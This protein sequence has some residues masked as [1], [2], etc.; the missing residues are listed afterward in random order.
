MKKKIFIG[1]GILVVITTVVLAFTVFNNNKNHALK[2][3]KETVDRGNIEALVVTT[4]SLNPVIVVDVGSQV[5][6]KIDNIYVDFNSTVK[7]GQVIAELD[8]SQFITRVNQNEANYQSSVASLEKAKVTFENIK[9]KYDRALG[10][11]EK[12]LVSFEEKETVETQ[13]YSAKADI[14]TAESRLAQAKSQLDSSKVDLTYTV[15]RSPIDGVIIDRR[16]NIGQTVAASFQAPVLFQIANDLSKMQV[17]CSVDEADIGKVKEGQKVRFNV[18]AFPNET[19]RGTVLQVR[20]SPEI[21]QNV[22]TY[23]SIIGVSNPDLKLRPGMTATVSIISGEAKNVLRVPNAAL[24]F[25]PPPEVWEEIMAGMRQGMKGR[26]ESQT[27]GEGSRPQGDVRSPGAQG[28]GSAQRTSMMSM[29]G[30][31]GSFGRSRMSNFAR[32]WTE[33]ENGKLHLISIRTG[34][35]DNTYTEI[36]EIVRGNLA[37]GQEVITG[38]ASGDESD[39]SRCR[40]VMGGMRFMRR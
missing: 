17:E 30:R 3:K 23:T 28:P 24:R 35:T 9:K 20:Y 37:E 8:Q 18:D 32:V 25:N 39:S 40:Y 31:S 6:G 13:Y 29:M 5:S 34:V 26:K 7:K 36:K 27:R 38:E 33:D 10:L 22:V 19:F 2:Y 12:N 4:G 11:F 1:A 15:I 16:V 14:R 21:V